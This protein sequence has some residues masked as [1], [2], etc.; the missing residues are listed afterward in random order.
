[1]LT[2]TMLVGMGLFKFHFLSSKTTPSVKLLVFMTSLTL[3]T[4]GQSVEVGGKLIPSQEHHRI[5]Y[6]LPEGQLF[7]YK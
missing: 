5:L 1:M 2:A 4:T 7:S 6:F 3:K